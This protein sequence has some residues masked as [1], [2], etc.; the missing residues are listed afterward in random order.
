MRRLNMQN[1]W[2][3]RAVLDGDSLMDAD[4]IALFAGQMEI[5]QGGGYF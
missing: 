3:L 1:E 5:L 2:F 4:T